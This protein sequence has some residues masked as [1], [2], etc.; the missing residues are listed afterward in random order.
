VQRYF[1]NHRELAELDEEDGI[2]MGTMLADAIAAYQQV[3]S[4][5]AE[6]GKLGRLAL[7]V[8]MSKNKAMGELHQKWSWFSPMIVKV[9][10]PTTCNPN[11]HPASHPTYSTSRF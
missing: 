4:G 1:Q 11:I 7:K 9:I 2:A 3:A 8:F 6:R 5:R 10:A